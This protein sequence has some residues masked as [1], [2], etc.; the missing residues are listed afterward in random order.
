MFGDLDKEGCYHRNL[1]QMGLQ[2]KLRRR[3]A[4]Y[5]ILLMYFAPMILAVSHT[6]VAFWVV[7]ALSGMNL[8]HYFWMSCIS[9]LIILGL[10]F[11]LMLALSGSRRCMGRKF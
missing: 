6:A 4:T 7:N 8:W 2:P 5:Q 9:Y 10:F 1:Y 11:Y 3:I